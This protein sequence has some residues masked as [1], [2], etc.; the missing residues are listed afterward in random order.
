MI[1]FYAG[2]TL[3]FLLIINYSNASNSH[4]G[5]ASPPV[6]KGAEYY[7]GTLVLRVKSKFRT[8]C[9]AD[10]INL[11]KIQDAFSGISAFDLKRKFPHASVPEQAKNKY[12]K[13]LIDLTLIYEV[14]FS[15]VIKIEEA[16]RLIQ[17]SGVVEYAEP[18]YVQFMDFTPNDPSASQQYQ[19]SK[20]NAY[21]AW[22]VWT[23]DTNVVIGIVDSG[24]DWDH[25]DLQA[26]IKY[27]YAD[28]IDGVDNDNDGFIDNYRGW[29]VS[30]SDNDP[31]VVSS[32]HGSHVSGCADAVTNNATGVA[33]PAYKC[34]FL[35]VKST[36]DASATTI[37]NG[38][39]GIVYAA[40]HGCNVINCSWGR[41]G[42]PSAFEQSV[43][44]YAT[45]NKDVLVVAAAGND[46]QEVFHYPSSYDKVIS[47][48]A[49]TATDGKATFSN[50]NS[51][52]DVCAPGDNILATIFD[53]SYARLD[54]TSMASPI[55]A[56]CAAMIK[57]KFPDFNAYQVGEQLRSTSDYIYTVTGNSAY[58][59]KLGKGRVNLFNCVSDSLSPGVVMDSY[60]AV[61][62]NDNVFIPGDTLSIQCLF[63]NLL[64]P[65]TNLVC[66][67]STTSAYVT[68]LQNN[69]NPGVVATMDTIS[70]FTNMYRV[71][72]KPTAPLNTEATFRVTV[73]D[74]TWKD[75]FIFKIIVNVDYINVAINNVATSITSK[76]L[77]GYN[78]TGQL[79]GLGFTYQN[80]T[81]I[82]YDM[83]LMVGA[84]GTQVSDN[85][86][87]ES[88]NDEDFAPYINVTSQEPG[89]IS[90]FDVNGVFKD[91]GSTSVAPLGLVI[92]HHA[93]AW[94]A[95]PDD[96]YVMVQ[97]FIKNN[98]VNNLT[99]LYAGIFSDWDIPA[100]ANNKCSTD[101]SRRLGYVWST[102]VAGLYGG[103][104]LLSHTGGFNHYAF[105]NLANSG[106]IDIVTGGFDNAEKYSAMSTSR[107]N[108]GTASAAGNDVLSAV[109]TGPFNL[110]VGDSV[111]VAFA[112]IAGDN[113][114]SIQTSSDAAQNM[115]DLKF[116]G[117]AS[118]GSADKNSLS[119]CFP[120][121]ASKETRIDFSIDKN[122]FTDLSIYN[123][124][125]VKVKT[126]VN[127]KIS[128]GKYSIPV[129]LGDLAP[130]NYLFKIISGDFIKTLP[131][132]IVK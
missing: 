117:I 107:S 64:R 88:G 70:N 35:P 94:V 104:K 66:S 31:M 65:T 93:Y 47:V 60:N 73:M 3:F 90:D 7:P 127:E 37:D 48:G 69:F 41:L 6:F 15:P 92:T 71:L 9:S 17:N 112:L 16:I 68:V 79:Q 8:S 52:V 72:V 128:S 113:L 2:V 40:D 1:R 23:G 119:P 76:G 12:G 55:A 24:T 20:I 100:F 56:G 122:N 87:N 38:W 75:V 111:E 114:S 54:G 82:L 36:H 21:A 121:P 51:T 63:E 85:V 97:Y 120:N 81:S 116:V 101:L 106:G 118:I 61:D 18:L 34:K 14:K 103:V 77:I 74:G 129:E 33:A 42:L 29:D 5:K 46:G 32:T 49:T 124:L 125:G 50:Y 53:N 62:N 96:N 58:V 30:E 99:D 80:G 45:D 126:V 13:K 4:V 102:D 110:A 59:G 105:D 28:P 86:R 123:I 130:G 22:D 67:L 27:N 89:V 131:M 132:I 98:G 43:I 108:S 11:Q 10:K 83:G 19:L 44:D 25:P 57:S 95:A 39:D 26:N 109:S 78:Q 91:N 84:S 115:Y